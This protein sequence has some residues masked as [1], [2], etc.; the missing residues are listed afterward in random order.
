MIPFEEGMTVLDALMYARDEY[1][2][3][4]TFRQAVCGSDAFL[5]NGTQRLGC[6]TQIDDLEEPIRVEPLAHQ[7]IIKD[8][9]VDMTDFYEKRYTVEPYLQPDDLLDDE[10]EEQR[11]SRENREKIEMATQ[12]LWCSACISSCNIV[13][14]N[15]HSIGPAPIVKGYRFYMDEREGNE[16]S[17]TSVIPSRGSVAWSAS[18]VA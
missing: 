3:S 10:L 12:Y 17:V 8:L 9:V 7:E 5:I 6:K 15:E 18:F 11:Q 14:G 1:D 16:G 4:L 13:Q 2:S